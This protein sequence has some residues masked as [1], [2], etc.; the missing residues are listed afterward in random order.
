ML[1]TAIAEP[2]YGAAY[3]L[4]LRCA[5]RFR[6]RHPRLAA[7]IRR[8]SPVIEGTMQQLNGL[9]AA[10]LYM[11]T[12]QTPN[13][14]A[15]LYTYDPSTAPGGSVSFDAIV[16]NVGRR[17][18]LS[19]TFRRRLA[20][21]PMGLDHPY[22]VEDADFDLEF[23]VRRLA[24]PGPGAWRDLCDLVARL[25]AQPI[26]LDRPPWEMY[27]IEGL[28]DGVDGI[29][30]N[31]FAMLIKIHH[32]AVDGISGMELMT[33]LHD[34]EP[35]A[36]PPAVDDRWQPEIPPPP[37]QLLNRAA[38]NN[39]AKPMHAVRVAGTSPRRSSASRSTSGGAACRRHRARCRGP[40]STLP[41]AR[42]ARSTRSARRSTTSVAPARPSPARL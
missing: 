21:V 19:R 15:A 37:W 9:D 8:R 36:E 39:L 12:A 42:T 16:A 20:S 1:D 38:L 23:H 31:G 33:V 10:M 22:W 11:E 2:T 4:G 34:R 26:N 30:R 14:V 24:L 40:A 27:I 18:A 3:E 35:D 7:R 25:Y 5:E 41:S 6:I 32:A 28:G 13:H 17:L 29:P